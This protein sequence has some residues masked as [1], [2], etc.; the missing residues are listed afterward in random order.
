M[1]FDDM[2]LRRELLSALDA[3]DYTHPTPIQEQAIPLVL[4]GRDL[5]CC[6]QTGTGKTAAY[7]LP[8]LHQLAAGERAD[9]R[10]LVLVPTRELAAPMY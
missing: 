6:A 5:V 7:A 3:C 9:I 2:G 8:I 1:T 10:A 4:E